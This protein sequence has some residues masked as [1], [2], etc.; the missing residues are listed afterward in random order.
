MNSIGIKAIA[1]TKAAVEADHTIWNKIDNG[2]YRIVFASPEIL[3]NP[4]SHFW[5][6]TL[7]NKTKFKKQLVTVA[8]DEC[9]L[10][11]D[12]KRFRPQYRIIGN[13]RKV[14]R[15]VPWVCLS[16]TLTRAGTAYVH[17]ACGLP[18]GT[19]QFKRTVRRRNINLQISAISGSDF[20][21][22]AR[23]VPP[24]LQTLGAIPKTLIYVDNAYDALD[25]AKVLRRRIHNDL[26]GDANA[27]AVRTYFAST[28]DEAKSLTLAAVRDGRCR[29]AICTDAFGL[30]VDIPDILRV[31]QWDI[32]GRLKLNALIQRLG[33]CARDP[34]RTGIG[35]IYVKQSILSALAQGRSSE[36]ANESGSEYAESILEEDY[37]DSDSEETLKSLIPKLS[38]RD[39]T[40][41]YIPIT[42]ENM[43][44][45][46][47]AV[48]H[49]FEDAK[50]LRHAERLAHLASKEKGNTNDKLPGVYKVDPG[51]L[52]MIATSGCRW[53]P[54][55]MLYEDD[56]VL[57]DD[58]SGWCCD[59]CASA[60]GLN[61]STTAI[62]HISLST[63]INFPQQRRVGPTML[64]KDAE[65]DAASFLRGKGLRV[66]QWRPDRP[67]QLC[68]ARQT[69]LLGAILRWRSGVF[70][71]LKL[72]SSMGPSIILPDKVIGELVSHVSTITTPETLYQRL[73]KS[74]VRVNSSLLNQ[75]ILSALFGAME[76]VMV[77]EEPPC[78]LDLLSG[79]TEFHYYDPND[80]E[81]RIP[82]LKQLKSGTEQDL[83][84]PK[85]SKKDIQIKNKSQT[86]HIENTRAAPSI[87]R[88]KV[89]QSS[90]DRRPLRPLN[91][92]MRAVDNMIS[93][94][95][96]TEK[97][98]IQP[99]QAFL[100]ASE[101]YA[102][103]QS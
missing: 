28:D 42:V 3:L 59:N 23:L 102:A 61:P 30:G 21:Q 78:Y 73:M 86:K 56:E 65:L 76:R 87:H 39:L 81:P 13:L 32:D 68:D 95:L 51:V 63:S 101:F 57:S 31:V 47:G 26:E 64:E 20:E 10:I 7:K 15:D 33:R 34:N 14:L 25:I 100:E 103:R 77:P 11:W 43:T 41:F 2:E 72:P 67:K 88:R 97:R 58:H 19:I 5:T 29:I 89:A 79:Y 93:G 85:T 37:S 27:L 36:T 70:D 84:P 35:V 74:K 1:A 24:N 60:K 6:V 16:A 52:W 8:V 9:H 66:I 80:P 50:N 54:A 75:M 99:S 94:R 90:K 18:N 83:R 48:Q 40:K 91:G 44:A 22:L 98:R 69:E 96:G 71:Y 62:H 53:R 38:K 49:M 17:R 46:Y 12:W 4:R 55:L 92:D 45:A 82:S